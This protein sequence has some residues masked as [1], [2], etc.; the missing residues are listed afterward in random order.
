MTEIE[1]AVITSR[2]TLLIL[3]PDYLESSWTEFEALMLQTLDPVNRERRLIPLLK[4][5]CDLPPRIRYL[6]YLDFATPEDLQV[7]WGRLSSSAE[8]TTKPGSESLWRQLG[9]GSR[10]RSFLRTATRVDQVGAMDIC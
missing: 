8:C 2:K 3:T 7:A 4:A 5:K 1:R 10:N 9:R 6:T